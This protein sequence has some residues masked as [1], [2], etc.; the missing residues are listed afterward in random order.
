MATN[1]YEQTFIWLVSNNHR[2]SLY[3]VSKLPL[4][5]LQQGPTVFKKHN[6]L[7]G[8]FFPDLESEDKFYEK[9]TEWQRLNREVEKAT[10]I[11]HEGYE[12]SLKPLEERESELYKTFCMLVKERDAIIDA[13]EIKVDFNAGDLPDKYRIVRIFECRDS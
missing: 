9:D 8:L 7:Y 11:S 1:Q 3:D 12:R 6:N 4:V 2:V 10:T 13:A 5:V